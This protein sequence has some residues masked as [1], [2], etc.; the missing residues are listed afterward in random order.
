MS[1]LNIIHMSFAKIYKYKSLIIDWHD[2]LGPTFLRHK[3]HEPKNMARISLRQWGEFLQW[4][5]MS[6]ENQEKYRIF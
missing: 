1:N 3:D 2:Y 5:S 6:K 4:H